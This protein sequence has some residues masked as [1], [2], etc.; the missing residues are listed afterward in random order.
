[1]GMKHGCAMRWVTSVIAFG[2]LLLLNVHLWSQD[3]QE[4]P[5]IKERVEVVNVEIP[6]RVFEKGEVVDTLVSGDFQ[7]FENGLE[8]KI[9]GFFIKRKKMAVQQVDIKARQQQ[10]QLKPRLFVLVFQVTSYNEA[11]KKG[12]ELLFRDIIRDQDRVL[13]FV[14]EKSLFLDRGYWEMERVKLL[15][16]L[17]AEQSRLA[18]QNLYA[19]FLTIKNDIDQMKN[20]FAEDGGRRTGTEPFQVIEFLKRY[21][22]TWQAYK[23]KHLLPDMDRYYNFSNYLDRINDEKWVINFYQIEMFPKMKQASE[24]RLRIS[25]LVAS[26]MVARSEDIVHSQI[27]E[28]LLSGIDRELNVSDDFPS[29]EIA[30]L[31]TRVDATYHTVMMSVEMESMSEDL[32]FKKISTDLEN[33]LRAIATQTG[34]A[35]Q[36]TNDMGAALHRLSEKEDVYYVLTYRPS[37]D[38]RAPKI[39][40]RLRDTA[41]QKACRLYY[42]DQFRA[43]YIA[44][45]IARRQQEQFVLEIKNFSF[46]DRTMGLEVHTRSGNG[47]VDSRS[48]FDLRVI[49]KDLDG[50]E[51]FNESKRLM[52]QG[53]LVRFRLGFPWLPAGKYHTILEI[54]DGSSGRSTLFFEEISVM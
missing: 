25:E 10:I 47:S 22:Q 33:N 37:Q 15:D 19:Y 30:R 54:T 17:L 12:V 8:Q 31:L 39:E 50:K 16:G 5:V 3:D 36:A 27:I 21:K 4:T 26:L 48:P 1:M 44:Q 45:Y 32:E 18:R 43:D 2:V 11:I 42:D 24:I 28:E 40:I 34:G 51:L 20:R 13:V 7:L 6:V 14:N 23:K 52:P 53:D 49:I 41:R 46:A 9:N 38:S 29:Q 35:L